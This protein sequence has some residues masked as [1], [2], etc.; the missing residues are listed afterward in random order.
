MKM[1]RTESFF[2]GDFFHET[3]LFFHM[4]GFES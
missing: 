4:T 2:T 3:N 1:I